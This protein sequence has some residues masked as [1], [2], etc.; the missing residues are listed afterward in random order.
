MASNTRQRK[1]KAR[2]E[3][4]IA[5]LHYFNRLKNLAVTRFEWLR[6]PEEI[7]IEYLNSVLLNNVALFFHDDELEQYLALERTTFSGINVYG[8][9][10]EYFVNAVNGYHRSLKASEC[11]PIKCTPTRANEVSLTTLEGIQYY[12]TQLAEIDRTM[13]VNIKRQKSPWLL[14]GDEN[15]ISTVEKMF[16]LIDENVP[17]IPVDS[18][19]NKL[20]Q[21]LNTNAPFIAP[22]LYD[23][24]K[25]VWQEALDFLGITNSSIEKRERVNVS[26]IEANNAGTVMSRYVILQPLKQ[27]CEKINKMFGLDVDVEFRDN[28]EASID[29]TNDDEESEEESNVDE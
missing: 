5:Y 11:V 18:D 19:F 4:T 23:L 9:P 21:V 26:E 25:S 24:K 10:Q 20:V 28:V 29:G 2:I 15:L 12:A 16:E 22:Q 3:N 8:R 6:M 27:A 7:D 1:T 14:E 13:F 17:M